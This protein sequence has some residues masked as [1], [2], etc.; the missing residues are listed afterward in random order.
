MSPFSIFLLLPRALVHNKKAE[1]AS[2]SEFVSALLGLGRVGELPTSK[3]SFPTSKS[4]N[5]GGSPATTPQ[6]VSSSAFAKPLLYQYVLLEQEFKSFDHGVAMTRVADSAFL[7]SAHSSSGL[8]FSSSSS[9]SVVDDL[10]DGKKRHQSTSWSQEPA[11]SNTN[12]QDFAGVNQGIIMCKQV[13]KDVAREGER[14]GEQEQEYEFQLQSQARQ[15]RKRKESMPIRGKYKCGHCGEIK[16]NH[17]CRVA[18]A[19]ES[20]GGYQILKTKDSYSQTFVSSFPQNIDIEP[21]IGVMIS[22]KPFCPN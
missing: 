20:D 6:V 15:G 16:T 9:N 2:E 21:Y 10:S 11:H 7:F 17:I 14:E 19:L 5:G 1:M 13:S 4:E 22:V 3:N 8:S 12:I 18:D